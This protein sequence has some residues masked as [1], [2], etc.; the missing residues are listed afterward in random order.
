MTVAQI[1]VA[2]LPGGARGYLVDCDRDYTETRVPGWAVAVLGDAAIGR[3]TAYR[4]AAECGRCD[5]SAVFDAVGRE[6][7]SEREAQELAFQ[8]L[9]VEVKRRQN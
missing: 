6:P 4:H 5:L 1:R 3:V 2:D 8:L 9:E 7:E